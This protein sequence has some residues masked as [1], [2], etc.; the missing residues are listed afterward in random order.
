MAEKIKENLAGKTIG[1]YLVKKE[2]AHGGMGVVYEAVHPE[3]GK[4]I[5]IKELTIHK[6]EIAER[7]KREA[8]ILMDMQSQYIVNT[9]DY[10]Q[11]G[12]S[13]YIV[14]EL[15]D[16]MSL[17]NLILH[18]G[19]LPCNIALIIFL[20]VCHALKFA[21]S[22]NIIHRDIKPAN[23]LLSKRAE[24]KLADFGI[25][26]NEKDKNISAIDSM[27]ATKKFDDLGLTQAKSSMGTP[28]YMAPE[29][30]TD[31]SSVDKTADI[32]SLGIMLFEMLTGKR[33]F[34]G[35]SSMQETYSERLAHKHVP[36]GALYNEK[37]PW[38]IYWMIRVMTMSKR[39][40]R[41]Q[42]IDPIIRIVT[43]YL[44]SYNQKELLTQISRMVRHYAAG[45]V[46]HY[47]IR[48]VLARR[49][50]SLW[51]SL[52]ISV[53]MILSW[54]F[55][56]A[57]KERFFYRIS[58]FHKKVTVTVS[59]PYN[60]VYSS[61][62]SAIVY[63]YRLDGEKETEIKA[64]RSGFVS[65]TTE[66]AYGHSVKK[67]FSNNIWL[68]KGKYRVKITMGQYYILAN[69]FIDST[70]KDELMFDYITMQKRPLKISMTVRGV[71]FDKNT[72]SNRYVDITD[73]VKKYVF[74]QG[75]WQLLSDV[76]N[77]L[78]TGGEWKIKLSATGYKDEIFTANVD[79]F[80]TELHIYTD[81]QRDDIK[82]SR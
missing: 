52:S 34:G 76:S 7:F 56:T 50:T 75:R 32:Y 69:M 20:N 28:A 37:I 71:E 51:V 22:K 27:A 29:Q 68:R 30:F 3:L 41:Y 66:K 48:P 79:W 57:V 63:F 9:Y 67:L 49:K 17:N 74:Y 15:V 1:K 21:H 13:R 81:M 8:L 11:D 65:E 42:S 61:D 18:H 33:P 46:T 54:L 2:I 19:K 60:S 12:K 62:L 24:V 10:F 23:I 55:V 47:E 77:R 64:M 25:A 45:N 26:G 82:E 39:E 35:G 70:S 4:P 31:S 80:Q 53:L 38:R 72:N 16:G 58:P 14:E 44:K 73:N 36:L 40:K 59:L 5:I 6:K 78:T 43:R